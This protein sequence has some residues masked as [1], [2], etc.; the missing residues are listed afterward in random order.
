[1]SFSASV[2][3]GVAVPAGAAVF[4]GV[5]ADSGSPLPQPATTAVNTA[6]HRHLTITFASPPGSWMTSPA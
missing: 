2:A 3:A 1:L 6:A 4:A 5:A